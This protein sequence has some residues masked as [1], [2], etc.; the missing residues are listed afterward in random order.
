[1]GHVTGGRGEPAGRGVRAP[2]GL[3]SWGA[4]QRG[5]NA[6]GV[7]R[8][9]GAGGGPLRLQ[10][11]VPTLPGPPPGPGLMSAGSAGRT[12]RVMA[13]TGCAVGARGEARGG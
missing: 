1:M 12:A 4:E 8:E 5:Q 3:L 13:R 6:S 2:G 7:A 10:W 9:E 11:A